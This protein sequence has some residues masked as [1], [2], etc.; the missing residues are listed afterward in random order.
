MTADILDLLNNI[1]VA[2]FPHIKGF[3]S[4]LLATILAKC[5]YYVYKLESHAAPTAQIHH[6]GRCH[7]VAS[8][9]RKR[10]KVYVLDSMRRKNISPSLPIKL[11]CL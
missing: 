9:Q 7:W 8:I 2:Q 5:W 1:L 4:T 6:N 11:A 10:G 3:K